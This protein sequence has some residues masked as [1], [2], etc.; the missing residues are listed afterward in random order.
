MKKT[1]VYLSLTLLAVLAVPACNWLWE[2]ENNEW[3]NLCEEHRFLYTYPSVTFS[4]TYVNYIENRVSNYFSRN[5][6][7][8]TSIKNA[9]AYVE[10]LLSNK[11][12]FYSDENGVVSYKGPT[13]GSEQFFVNMMQDGST[14]MVIGFVVIMTL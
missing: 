2:S 9:D 13:I 6:S 11:F 1:I 3:D 14:E 10:T 8:R 7:I 12:R 4:F 5:V